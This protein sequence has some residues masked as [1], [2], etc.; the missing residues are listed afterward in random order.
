VTVLSDCTTWGKYIAAYVL[1]LYPPTL[2]NQI[3]H[4]L[5]GAC[6]NRNTCYL[7]SSI[8]CIS[9][10]PIFRE[11]FTS[12]AYLNDI[13]TTNPLGYQGHLAQV[14]AVLINSLWKPF[15]QNISVQSK[16]VTAPGSYVMV[17]AQS[18]TPKTFK[19]SLG[20]FNELFSGN[21]Q[22]DA[23][24]L[25]TFLLGGLS[26]DLNRIMEK[27]YIEAPDS[28]GRPDRELADIWWANHLR[29]E[30]SI[31]VAL[32]TGQYKNLLTCRTC[33][34]ES[35]RFEPFATL[36]VPLPEDDHLTAY[37]ILYP[38][39]DGADTLKYCLRVRSD[40]NL[41]D[42]LLELAK[43]LIADE[44]GSDGSTAPKTR[45]DASGEEKESADEKGTEKETDPAVIRR[46]QNL[47]VV[48]MRDGYIFKI[49]PNSWSLQDLQNKDTGDLPQL[50]IYVLDN[51]P[52]DSE[53]AKKEKTATEGHE[54]DSTNFDDEDSENDQDSKFGF[55]AIVQRRSEVVSRDYLHPLAHRV[56]G[57]PL[58]VRMVDMENWT[59]RQLYDMVARRLRNIVPKTALRFLASTA[60]PSKSKP[61]SSSTSDDKDES[62]GSSGTLPL[63][64][65][66]LD[67]DSRGSNM[68]TTTTDMEEVSAGSVP[69]YGFRLRVTTRDG[70]RCL[71]CPWYKCCIGCLVPDDYA[72]A[73]VMNGDSVVVDW[74]FAVDVATSGFGLRVPVVDPI[75]AQPS[76][77]PRQPQ[78]SSTVTVKNHSSC[79]PGAKRGGGQ[80]GVI[81]LEECLDA[82]AK[83][84]RIPEAFCSKCKDFRVQT[85]RMTLWRL[86]PVLIIHL[87][88][89]QFT[90][91]MR[92]KL[93]D[94]VL[95]PLE[96]LDLSRIMALDGGDVCRVVPDAN[97]TKETS[98]LKKPQ[99]ENGVAG[100]SK[101]TTTES[102]AAS[103]S[104]AD[105][106]KDDKGRSE[107]LYDLYGVVHHQGALSGGHYVASLKSELDGQWRLF[108][109]AQIYEIHARDVVDSSAY[110]LFYIRR[111][112][113]G[114]KLSDVWNVRKE[115]SLSAEDMDQLLK[116]K[117]DRCVI[118]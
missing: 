26:E 116:G 107:M 103:A 87:K 82:F 91:T 56:F 98:P 28:D 51:V 53:D 83:E 88:R 105:G 109:D 101:Q 96:G 35:A 76:P 16:R 37:C 66:Q 43:V 3:S 10:T 21:E 14:S 46:A 112:M 113:I 115:G 41:H 12:K 97:S 94:L 73:A 24:E 80:S 114:K 79:G 52:D 65:D 47:A 60:S 62:S 27:P 68:S 55:L 71:I 117:S 93:R 48:D 72:P 74:H 92:R 57:T 8:Q 31:V 11:Y 5:L 63:P 45:T 38:L 49:A 22:H 50:H 77:M 100:N 39:A 23:Q 70:R 69:R 75:S 84:E 102:G 81:T 106:I 2:T 6:L 64:A 54:D 25:L 108:N 20:K 89:F 29:R 13:N 1:R 4:A 85:T 40:G 32:F 104:E 42:V 58:L 86:P 111:D 67:K 9:H 36:T 15:N 19:E 61:S 95:F 110:I 90:Q 44:E 17:N 118:S 18:L 99:Q 30:M 7:N 33:K 59:G 34:Y 78:R